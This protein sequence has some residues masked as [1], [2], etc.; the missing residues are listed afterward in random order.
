MFLLAALLFGIL[1]GVITAIGAWLGGFNPILFLVLAFVFLGIQYLIGPAIVSWTMKVKWVSEK[2]APKLHAIVAEQAE[3][4]G[5]PKPKVDI[6]TH[7]CTTQCLCLWQDAPRWAGLFHAG[8]HETP[9]Q[10]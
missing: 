10:R 3:K 4:A 6:S 2:E 7:C 1:Y 8:N 5:I 9:E